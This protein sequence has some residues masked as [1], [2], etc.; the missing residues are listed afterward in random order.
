MAD[1]L[2]K[3]TVEEIQKRADLFTKSLEDLRKEYGIDEL[4]SVIGMYY[5]DENGKKASAIF[6]GSWGDPRVAPSLG[7]F[8][9]RHHTKPELDRAE[10]LKELA[11]GKDGND[12]KDDK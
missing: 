5:T 12:G 11:N 9:Y 10:E 8:A 7:A 4:L 6:S 2:E 1:K 3:L